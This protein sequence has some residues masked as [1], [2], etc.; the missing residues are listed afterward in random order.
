MRVL[1]NNGLGFVDYTKH[2]MDGTLTVEDSINV[3]TLINFLLSPADNTFVVPRRSAYVKIVSEILAP[4]ASGGGY[5]GYGIGGYGSGYTGLGGGYGSGKILATG[6]ITQEPERTFLGLNQNRGPFK[7]IQYQYNIQVTSDEWLLN[8]KTVPYIPAFVNQTDSQILA[9][10]AQALAP[11][12]Y[13][14]TSLMATGTLVPYYAYDP[15]QT[16]S[17]IAKSFADAN[18]YHYKVI[19]KQILYQPFGDA[20]LGIEYDEQLQTEAQINPLELLSHVVNVPPINDCIVLGDTEPQTNWENYFIGDGFS[21]NFPLRHQVF[22]GT[23]SNLLQDDWTETSLTQGTWIQNDPQGIMTLVDGNGNALGALNLVQ[24]GVTGVYLPQQNATYLQAQNGLE[25]GGGL[26]LQHGQFTFN[27][28]CDGLMGSIFPSSNFVPGNVLAGFAA[29]GQQPAGPYSITSVQN[30]A[31]SNQITLTT[32]AFTPPNVIKNLASGNVLACAGFTNATFLNGQK[33]FI[34]SITSFQNS[35]NQTQYTILVQSQATQATQYGPTTDSGTIQAFQNDVML[36][37]SGAA[38]IVIQPVL[39]GALVGPQVISQP[40]HQYVLQTWIGAGAQTRFTRPYTNL[41]QTATYGAQNL[42]SSGTITWV[43]T[44]VNLGQYVIEQQN[45]LFGLFPAAPPPVVTKYSVTNAI[46]PPF[47]LYCLVNAINLNISINYTDLSLPPQ[48]FLTVQSLTGI[49]GGNLPVLPSNLT[50]PV[51]YQLGFGMINQTAQ[52]SQSGEVFELSFY[53]DDIPSVGARIMFQ[54]WSAGQSVARVQDPIAIAHEAAISGDNGIRSAIMNNLSPIPRTSAECEAAAAAAILDREYPQFQGTYTVECIPG[55]Y[56][57][58]YAPSVYQYPETGR[59]LYIN[60]QTRAITG[61]NFFVNTVR[62]QVVELR[63]EVM[64]ISLDFG[65]DL[66]LEKLL[67]AFLER[68]QNVLTPTQTVPPP[69]PITLPQVLNAHLPTLDNAHIILISDS[70]TGNYVQIDL[71]ATPATACE[72]R[73]VDGGWGVADQG[74]VGLFTTQQFT[75]PRTAR[76]QTWY[77]R[78]L[79]GA[80]FSRFSKALRVVYPLPPT[81][82][83]LV[84]ANASAITLNFAG[85][86]RD[87]Y[88]MELRALS[89]SGI[90]GDVIV[91]LPT[92]T[93]SN[94][95]VPVVCFQRQVPPGLLAYTPQITSLSLRGVGALGTYTFVGK[96]S[97]FMSPHDDFLFPASP[98]GT[99][100]FTNYQ[101]GD[102]VY[103]ICQTDSSFTGFRVITEVTILNGA[104]DTNNEVAFSC[105]D[106]GLP[107]PDTVGVAESTHSRVNPQVGTSQLIGRGNF[108]VASSGSFANGVATVATRTPHGLGQGGICCIGAYWA[109]SPVFNGGSVHWNGDNSIFCGTWQVTNV[110]DAFTF[111]FNLVNPNLGQITSCPATLLNG[112]V[113]AFPATTLEFPF[114]IPGAPPG[115]LLQR[116]IFAPSD[117]IIDLTKPGV[118]DI[119]TALESITPGSRVGGLEALFFN[120]QWDYST[121]TAIPSFAVPM[122]SGAFIE[123]VSQTLQWGLA[124]GLPDGHRIETFDVTTGNSLSKFTVDHPSNPILLKRA[125]IPAADWLNPRVFKI[126]PF[127][128]LGDGIPSFVVWGGSSGVPVIGGGSL[129]PGNVGDIIRY[130]VNGDNTWD[131]VNFAQ[132]AVYLWADV[133]GSGSSSWYGYGPWGAGTTIATLFIVAGGGANNGPPLTSPYLLSPGVQVQS[134]SS[135]ST[136]TIIAMVGG[137]VGGNQG[138]ISISSVYKISCRLRI[139]TL[140]NIRVWLGWAVFK[141]GSGNGV[142]GDHI[143]NSVGLANDTPNKT[144]VAFRY[145]AGVDTNWQAVCSVAGGSVSQTIVNTGVT[146]DTNIHLFEISQDYAGQNIYFYIDQVLVAQINTNIPT[147]T[148]S[149]ADSGEIFW[150]GDNKNTANQIKISWWKLHCSLRF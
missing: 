118:A 81:P 85:D 138:N 64:S 122:I 92:N 139:D 128:G 61:Q 141:N 77:L 99:S 9:A 41:T 114:S 72:V 18:R 57:S 65:P 51:H 33:V 123:P 49:S 116:P 69:N 66:Y 82:P 58:L 37:A 27:D 149:D 53:T 32:T 43:I 121:P 84:G 89:A 117:L 3:P 35:N 88:G 110:I 150:C 148:T 14:T 98:T 97:T 67:P 59:Y 21:S 119:L 83:A 145:S 10:I 120:E 1:I 29:T 105:I 25:L 20:P 36:T 28:F 17:D 63:S 147:G 23:S 129:G 146:V 131:A 48:G 24:K 47:A 106:F 96:G 127:D 4:D 103:L 79:N 26:N 134:G 2:V 55:R 136:S 144:M 101:L 44:D 133:F 100:V 94:P 70:L 11:G 12:F 93:S 137:I 143:E 39:S 16:W 40:N 124:Q 142:N 126:T 8:C 19:N 56:E 71:G 50:N 34:V 74:R 111:Q 104:F 108:A 80:I 73:N 31:N 91:Q 13:D 130:N 30:Y 90:V 140:S 54:S 42:A 107:Y 62:I 113:A 15:S 60:A 75:V 52:I 45:P 112:I 132:D 115:T 135:A 102:I 78:T 5:G 109:T 125:D 22:Q 87:I 68:D 46:L 6:F 38:G 7:Y 76:D 95:I 86:V